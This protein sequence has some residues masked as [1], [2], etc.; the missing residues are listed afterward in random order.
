MREQ[1]GRAVFSIMLKLVEGSAKP[2]VRGR[3]KFYYIALGSFRE[4]QCI[5]DFLG[6]GDLIQEADRLEAHFYRLCKS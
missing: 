1:F 4:V 3:K 2:P 6:D 5:L